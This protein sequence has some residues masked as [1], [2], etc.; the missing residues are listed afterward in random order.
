MVL[1]SGWHQP[2]NGPRRLDKYLYVYEFR[3]RMVFRSNFPL[4][5][6]YLSERWSRQVHAAVGAVL[7]SVSQP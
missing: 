3:H 4:A 2:P 5:G 7:I 1:G 6:G